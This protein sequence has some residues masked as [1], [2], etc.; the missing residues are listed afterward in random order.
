M[1]TS[2]HGSVASGCRRVY[3]Q[4]RRYHLTQL[5][6]DLDATARHTLVGCYAATVGWAVLVVVSATQFATQHPGGSPYLLLAA[7]H[8][9]L[10]TTAALV[11]ENDRPPLENGDAN[12]T[13]GTILWNLRVAQLGCGMAFLWAESC[14]HRRYV[15]LRLG[16]EKSGRNRAPHT[17]QAGI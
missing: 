13:R 10:F 4:H 9:L 16:L 11:W 1:L 17:E 6:L 7:L 8:Q 3:N 15:G 2:F 12:G 14:V 5:K